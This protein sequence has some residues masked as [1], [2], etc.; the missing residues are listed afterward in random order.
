MGK[1]IACLNAKFK[2]S[3]STINLN[4]F[5]NIETTLDKVKNNINIGM[6]VN[7]PA[8]NGILCL[9]GC[10]TNISNLS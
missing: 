6:E 8:H 1:H 5:L 4:L 3:F 7:I 9:F 2:Y 10:D